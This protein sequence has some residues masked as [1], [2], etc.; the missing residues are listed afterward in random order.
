MSGTSLGVHRGARRFRGTLLFR[1]EQIRVKKT[2]LLRNKYSADTF[3][4][5]TFQV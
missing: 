2:V 4:D 5:V 1:V 3:K